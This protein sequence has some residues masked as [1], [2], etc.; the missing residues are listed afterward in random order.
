MKNKPKALVLTGY[1]INC[2]F[3]TKNALEK[4]GFM[5]G[6]VH[7]ND[8]VS[9]KV[10]IQ[11]FQLM[12]FPGGFSYGDDL[13]AG[14]AMAVKIEY[15]KLNNHKFREELQKFVEEKNLVIGICNG[16]QI[17]VKLGL[18]PAM[19]SKFFEQQATLTFN[20]S[21]KFEDRWVKLKANSKS[22]CV[23][24]KG[25]N[26]IYL[27]VRH[28][29]GKFIARDSKIL[30]E[31]ISKNQVCLQYAGENG[32]PTQKYPLN[33]NGSV[34]AIAG[35]CNKQGNVFGL[36]PHPEAHVSFYNNPQWTRIAEEFKRKNRKVHE[37]G[38]GLKVFR[39]SFEYC[40]KLK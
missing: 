10:S 23:F 9:G 15:A 38:E 39:N 1:G 3:E 25:I 36:M 16:F 30:N 33:P 27:P 32:I 7:I 11:D 31:L 4:A 22:K 20:D 6:R 8:L 13:G 19:E 28:G 17:I 24:T 29:E 34:K 14:K 2:D 40:K 18:L 26:K 35:I 5:A 12:A 37:E 21:G